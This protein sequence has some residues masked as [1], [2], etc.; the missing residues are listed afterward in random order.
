M[1]EERAQDGEGRVPCLSQ[2]R[3]SH[4]EGAKA[5]GAEQLEELTMRREKLQRLLGEEQGF[6]QSAG[7][8]TEAAPGTRRGPGVTQ[9]FWKE[10]QQQR[11]QDSTTA[12]SCPAWG[13]REQSSEKPEPRSPKIQ[14]KPAGEA[15]GVGAQSHREQTVGTVGKAPS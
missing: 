7:V 12:S 3:P 4:R 13:G 14:G 8:R 5:P 1:E 11:E 9:T 2:T 10:S 6:K 15:T